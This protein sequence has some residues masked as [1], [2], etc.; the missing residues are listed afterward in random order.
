VTQRHRSTPPTSPARPRIAVVG[1]G[2][3][4]LAAAWELVAGNDRSDRFSPEVHLFEANG[5]IG[6]KLHAAEFTGRHVDVA[7]DAFL[8]RRPEAT[9]LCRQLGLADSLVPVGATGASIWARGRLRPMPDGLQLGVP[10]RWWP[11]ARSGI[12]SLTESA[13]MARD[14]VPPHP[15]SHSTMGDRSVGDI[16]GSRL[17][18]PVVERLVDPLV[19]GINAGGVDA[20]SAATV[21]PVLLAASHQPGSLMRRL[22]RVRN[23]KGITDD[24]APTPVFWSLHGSTAMLA[25]TLADELIRRGVTIHTNAPVASIERL[26]P[27]GPGRTSWAVTIGATASSGESAG[28]ADS[29]GPLEMDGVVL[30]LPASGAAVLLAALAPEAAGLLNAIEYASVSVVTLSLPTGAIRAPLRGTGFLVPRTSTI[31]G[32]P[33]MITGCTYL[34]RKWPHLARPGDELIR[35]SVGRFGDIRHTG[36]G[37]DELTT[38]VLDEL[39]VLLGLRGVPLDSLVTRWDRAFPQYDVGHLLRVSR[40]EQ[41]V[42]SLQ[43]VG[44]AGAAL[45][46]VGIPACIGS[47]RAAAGRV[48]ASLGEGTDPI[49]GIDPTEGTVLEGGPGR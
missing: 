45:R 8:A 5:R 20:L 39:G 10:T 12:L 19:G 11:L 29:G 35:A 44:V 34:A 7:A 32:R 27:S 3:A 22:G 48:M 4:G 36:L 47:G 26:H 23:P 31:D 1:A 33:S 15:G 9:E 46:G 41:L 16:V 14:L 37:D 2:I 42:A 13:A 6:G 18:R 30:T 21:F 49:P 24:D 38:S 43:G 17:G 28:H 25:D 40:I